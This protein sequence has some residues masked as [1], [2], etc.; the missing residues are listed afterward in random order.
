M[1]LNVIVVVDA[2]R[3]DLV[4]AAI[5][6]PVYWIMMSIAAVKAFYQLAATPSYW[7][8]TFHGLDVVGNSPGTHAT[9]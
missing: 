5:L 7:E 4:I 9:D 3:D 8:K 2:G 6:S 1:Y